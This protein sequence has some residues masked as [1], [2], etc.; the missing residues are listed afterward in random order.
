MMD[1]GMGWGW[2][3]LGML[4]FWL[5]PI[6]VLLAAIKYLFFSGPRGEP[7]SRRRDN[8]GSALEILEERYAKGEMNR[9]EFL[10]RRDDLL[11]K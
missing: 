10:E 11:R 1:Y 3:W 6:V 2:A 8:R 5:V 9:Q 4:L 7:E